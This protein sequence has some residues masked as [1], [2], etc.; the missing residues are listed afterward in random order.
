MDWNIFVLRST[1]A[2]GGSRHPCHLLLV[3]ERHRAITA[4][5]GPSREDVLGPDRA[6]AA[7]ADLGLDCHVESVL[8]EPGLQEDRAGNRPV[9]RLVLA[10]G[11]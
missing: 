5:L 9:I 6:H 4:V 11:E 2:V 10:A 8:P 1:T 3:P 7:D